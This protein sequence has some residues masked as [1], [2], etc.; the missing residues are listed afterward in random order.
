MTAAGESLLVLYEGTPAYWSYE[1]ACKYND[2]VHSSDGYCTVS[3]V[4]RSFKCLSCS[5]ET[6]SQAA[7][8][9]VIA[10]VIAIAT[11]AATV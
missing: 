7:V 1:C 3:I 11:A 8:V 9:K 5:L 10:A 2:S 6:V 4:A